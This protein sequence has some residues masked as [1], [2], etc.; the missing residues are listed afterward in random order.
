MK[1]RELH[2]TDQLI[3]AGAAETHV[4]LRI[5]AVFSQ[6]V[7]RGGEQVVKRVFLGWAPRLKKY[8]QPPNYVPF[9]PEPGI[10]PGA[11][12]SSV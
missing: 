5:Y 6:Y 12:R 8:C 11:F 9:V 10:E 2:I 3:H 4:L 1:T 7:C